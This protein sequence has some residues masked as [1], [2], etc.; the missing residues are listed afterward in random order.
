[1][2]EAA[3][4]KSHVQAAMGTEEDRF[5]DEP[6]TFEDEPDTFQDEPDT[7]QDEPDT[8]Q[9]EPNEEPIPIAAVKSNQKRVSW[10]VDEIKELAAVEEYD[11]DDDDE[12]VPWYVD[13][14]EALVVAGATGVMA[15]LTML[16]RG[17][18][19]MKR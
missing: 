17:Y 14:Q 5:E 12:D 7:F 9:D 18:G 15:V 19:V 13:H 8:F 16:L 10:G 1:M 2:E 3:R 6:D 11:E 4:K